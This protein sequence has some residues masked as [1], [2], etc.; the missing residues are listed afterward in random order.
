MIWKIILLVI[1]VIIFG[2][3]IFHWLGLVFNL[4]ST[5]CEWIYQ[6]FDFLTKLFGGVL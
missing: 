4:L 2:P 6:S 1:G 5:I 3:V